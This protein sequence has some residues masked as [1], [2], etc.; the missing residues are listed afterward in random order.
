LPAKYKETVSFVDSATLFSFAY[1]QLIALAII[2]LLVY[3]MFRK[4]KVVVVQSV[5]QTPVS[6]I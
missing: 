1:I 6:S 3:M 5:I 2:I 4:R